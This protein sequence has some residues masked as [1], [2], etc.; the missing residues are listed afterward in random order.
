ME[1]LS[2]T[3]SVSKQCK[4]TMPA[5]SGDTMYPYVGKLVANLTLAQLKTLDCKSHLLLT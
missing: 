4:D 5:F 2:L 3:P 1:V